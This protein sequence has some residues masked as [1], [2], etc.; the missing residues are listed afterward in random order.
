MAVITL[1]KE[2]VK[3]IIGN[4]NDDEIDNLLSLFGAGVENIDNDNINVEIAA[5][6]ADLLS[7]TLFMKSLGNFYGNKKIKEYKLKK[8][9]ENYKIKINS[10]LKNIRPF[11][12]CS[13]V[14]GLELDEDKIK[15]IVNIQEKLHNTLCRN[16]KKAAIGIYPLDKIKMPIK[17][18]A[19]GSKEIKFIPLGENHDMDAHDILTKTDK[20]REYSSLLEKHEKFPVFVDSNGKIM[21]MPPIINSDE[22]GKI[23]A[24]TRDVFVECSGFDIEFLKKILNIVSC[25]LEEMG[26]SVY[27]VELDYGEYKISTPDFKM[28]K[29]SLDLENVKKL[30]G[31]KINEKDIKKLF[32]RM[33]LIYENGQVLIPPYRLDISHENDLIEDIA[34]AYGYDKFEPTLG[35]INH[36]GER[37][38]KSK[39]DD[40]IRDIL[41]GL[42]FLETN[43]YHLIRKEDTEILKSECYELEN[44]KT[45]YKL[46]RNNL[47]IPFL[48][49]FSEN[50]DNEY[51][52]KIFEIGSV[53]K[54]DK[55]NKICEEDKLIIAFSPSNFTSMK[56]ILDYL[57]R[58]LGLEYGIEEGN[59]KGLVEGRTGKIIFRNNEI[60]Y[61]GEVHP[62]TLK[63]FGI[64]M[65][66]GIV[67]ISLERILQNC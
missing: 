61:I 44:A 37:S 17:Y 55:K 28:K 54:K 59:E 20:G 22:I 58:L 7:E 51:P 57:F 45:E 52:Q 26:G 39:N 50:K 66:V 62:Q 2:K 38:L 67:E 53:F 36:F 49:I 30:L 16:R 56:Q 21:S 46:L 33:D 4:K 35:N 10:N 32:E 25:C 47:L 24:E 40:K 64:K 9:K 31:I 42:G 65:P 1:S 41:I 3:N 6:R 48:K 27:S 34:I 13:V 12:A 18:E 8:G 11:T 14:L 60:G 23:T 43:T 29:I 63:G 5:N 19:R 15:D